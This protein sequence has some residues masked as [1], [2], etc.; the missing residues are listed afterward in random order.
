MLIIV[1]WYVQ[2]KLNVILLK[3]A[4]Y[5]KLKHVEYMTAVKVLAQPLTKRPQSTFNVTVKINKAE[6]YV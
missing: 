2:N 6:F 5:K 3:D 4:Y 1:V